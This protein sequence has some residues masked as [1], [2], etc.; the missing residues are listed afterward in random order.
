MRRHL[1]ACTAAL[2]AACAT[3]PAGG[4]SEATAADPDREARCLRGYPVDCRALGRAR[5]LGDG[6]ARDDRLG[7]AYATKACELGDSAACSDLSVLSAV[8]RG[9]S[10]S[11]V[12]AVALSRRACEGGIALA[13]SNL[14]VLTAE[15]AA[16]PGLRPDEAG[17]AGPRTMHLFRTACDAGVPEGCLALGTSL[18]SGVLAPPDRPGA[19]RALRRACEAGLGLAC[20][21]LGLL[22]ARTPGLATETPAAA[23]QARAC[24][25]G[26]APA[27][28]LAGQ[29]VPAASARTPT[30][31]LVQEP[32]SLALGIPGAGGIHPSDL[33]TVAGGARRPRAE[34]RRPSQAL[35]GAMTPEL[36][37]RLGLSAEPRDGAMVDP[38][39]ELLMALR[40]QELGGCYEVP[41]QSSGERTEVLVVFL[42]EADGKPDEVRAAATPADPGLEACAAERVSAWEFPMPAGGLAGPYLARFTYEAAP[43]RTPPQLTP[44]G[45]L[46]PTLKQPGCVDRQVKL[47]AELAELTGTAT[48]K[49]A[50]DGN[51][52][53][54]LFHA[55]TPAPEALVTAMGDAVRACEWTPGVD[56]AGRPATLWLTVPVHFGTR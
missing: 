56:A 15:G 23:L 45:G 9:V 14:G 37:Q 27:C 8:G 53:P 54:M 19:A 32:R 44:P 26:I 41:R 4:G 29:P 6:M 40:R 7:A 43:S 13:C 47:P 16:R 5:L 55:I 51:G 28:E 12:R 48:V 50:V 49:L 17:D 31:R 52:T 11:D 3:V 20:H 30:P 46:R 1:L 10:Q 39:V 18:E 36:R 24:Q 21:R 2:L 33:A 42:L 35:L 25:D 22:A 34:V 38:A